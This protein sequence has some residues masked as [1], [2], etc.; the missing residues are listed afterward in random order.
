LTQKTGFKYLSLLCLE[1]TSRTSNPKVAGSS[2]AGRV[3]FWVE[4]QS[5]V[6]VFGG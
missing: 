2:P 4:N 5:N 3:G 6:Q 1:A